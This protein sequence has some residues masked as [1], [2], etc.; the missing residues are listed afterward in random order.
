MR[1]S[2]ANQVFARAIDLG[3]L[4]DAL[5]DAVAVDRREIFR[6]PAAD[7]EYVGE[8]AVGKHHLA[9]HAGTIRDPGRHRTALHQRFDD[10]AF[11][12]EDRGRR[13][14]FLRPVFADDERC[15]RDQSEQHGERDDAPPA[16]VRELQR[17]F[18]RRGLDR[19][20]LVHGVRTNVR[21]R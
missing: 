8:D 10:V 4:L 9:R 3:A 6:I 21:E 13:H 12:D 1:I 11:L 18:A 2:D 16:F 15:E 20:K 17:D 7:R 19:L 5:G 14:V